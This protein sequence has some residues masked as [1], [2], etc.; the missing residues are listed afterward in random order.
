M[1]GC[2][3]RVSLGHCLFA[4]ADAALGWLPM[5]TMLRSVCLQQGMSH[6]CI[7]GEKYIGA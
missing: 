2:C 7:E 4:E 3:G 5:M 6:G 1:G